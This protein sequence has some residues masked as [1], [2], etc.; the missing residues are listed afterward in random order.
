MGFG[1]E[2][3]KRFDI[4][5]TKTAKA[6][7]STTVAN[8]G[9]FQVPD[10]VR[11]LCIAVSYDA[12]ATPGGIIELV[13]F[14][15]MEEPKPA[16][17]DDVFTIPGVWDGTVTSGAGVTPVAG[18]DW[19]ATPNFG[20]VVHTQL[21]LRTPTTT[22]ASDK[23]RIDW[24]INVESASWIGFQIKE[25]SANTGTAWIRGRFFV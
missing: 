21:A 15:T 9:L 13:P 11:R 16:I 6:T 14:M 23:V 12:N 5:G 20:Q 4:V 1:T 7:V 8:F 24:T 3:G 22:G 19:T 17:G 2:K 18:N 25:V 10:F